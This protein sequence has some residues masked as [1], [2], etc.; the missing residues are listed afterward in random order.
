MPSTEHRLP[1]P[2]ST[3][4]F[5]R[6]LA[7]VLGPSGVVYLIGDLGA[8]KT[9]IVRGLLRGLGVEGPVKSPTYTLIESYPVGEGRWVHHLDLYRLADAGELE[10]LGVRDLFGAGSLVLI[11]WPERGAGE[12]PPPD[13]TLT[14]AIEGDGR[15]VTLVGGDTE[16]LDKLET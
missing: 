5:G 11:E 15:R 7:Q 8:G 13:L 14:L 3:D 12:L 1:D 4:R 16:L 6:R 10:W 2:A 9:S